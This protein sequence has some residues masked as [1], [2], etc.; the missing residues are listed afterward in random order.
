MVEKCEDVLG[1]IK[2]GL[3]FLTDDKNRNDVFEAF[4][5]ANQAMLMQRKHFQKALAKSNNKPEP[6]IQEETWRPF[7]IAFIL[8]NL[9]SLA[10]KNSSP[11][12]EVVD[13]LWLPTASG[14]TEAYL[15][16]A[17]FIMLLRRMRG[18]SKP[19]GGLGVTVLLRYTLRLLTLNQFERAATLMCAL[20]K[21]RRDPQHSA[22]FGKFSKEPFLVGLWVGHSLTPNTPSQSRAALKGR[23]TENSP[24]QLN[25]CPWCG[26]KVSFDN[27]QVHPK[28]K[29]TIA[30]CKSQGCSFYS[31]DML[32]TDNALPI[33]TVD[34][35]IYRR[36]PSMIISTV[37]K[38]ARLPWKEDI[39]SIFGKIEKK[40]Q[41]CG[42]I[43]DTTKIDGAEHSSFHSG[44]SKILPE[45][46]PEL[47]GPDL[48]IQ[49]ELHLIAGPLGSM[50]GLYETAVEYLSTQKESEKNIR[51]KIIVSTATS[52]G[53]DVQVKK[54][55][56]RN[57]T[58][59]FPP[60]GID[61]GDAFFW[62][63]GE[64]EGRTYVGVSYSHR[65][66]K[67]TLGR[68]YASLL[69]RAFE[70][71]QS[72]TDEKELDLYWTLVGY[73]NST[74]ELGGTERLVK[75]DVIN[76]IDGMAKLYPSHKNL[77]KRK[78]KS[79]EELTGRVKQDEIRKIRKRIEEKLSSPDSI[80][81]LLATN[82]I[83]VGIDIYRLGLMVVVGQPKNSSE[84]IQATGRVGRSAETPGLVFTLYNPYKPR[85]LSHY[86]NFIGYHN[87]LQKFVEPVSLTP[88]SERAIE[89]GLHAV[90]IGL[91]RQTIPELSLNESAYQFMNLYND[92][93]VEELKTQ[94]LT[95]CK[96]VENIDEESDKFKFLDD[97]LNKITDEWRRYSEEKFDEKPQKKV[98]YWDKITD[99]PLKKFGVPTLKNTV[100]LMKSYARGIKK[101]GE[102][103]E[104][105]SFFPMETPESLRDVEA[106]VRF[107]Y[108]RV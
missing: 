57:D 9:E 3:E 91:I 15:G 25:F 66:M 83:S 37:D 55:F 75:D 14:K 49:D 53:V 63:E 35:D 38:F 17:A 87:N 20:E 39:G 6:P 82:M 23:S 97:R 33:V 62:W 104:D 43:S 41:Q 72:G 94:I 13:L 5:L 46:F 80:D 77:G 103:N 89:R 44:A 86:E 106:Q 96:N 78:I 30:H 60:P 76:N 68:I 92:P 18:S 67:F 7:Q 1:R 42:F 50:T 70:L 21:I 59:K 16:L 36:C 90:L 84:Y 58:T 27:F 28:R 4:L 19:D 101:D 56:D 74:R 12:R 61:W 99:S 108:R 81:I 31:K 65:S 95:R 24:A 105:S 88:F 40:C 22:K 52:S 69:Q 8:M 11:E 71:L 93:A 26:E 102:K 107:S 54:L 73:F 45:K 79:T 47:D 48:I 51:P 85:D 2:R 34:D 98:Y 29:W 10:N 32:E 100:Y 64:S